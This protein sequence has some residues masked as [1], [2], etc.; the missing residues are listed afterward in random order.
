MIVANVAMP[1]KMPM[2]AWIATANARTIGR[3][4]AGQIATQ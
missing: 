3:V 2:P 4:L 1:K